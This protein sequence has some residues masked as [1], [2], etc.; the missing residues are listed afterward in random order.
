M[1]QPLPITLRLYRAA[2]MAFGPFAGVLLAHRQRRGKEDAARRP[3]RLGIAG[4]PRPQGRLCWLHGASVGES[5]TLL[6]V[7]ERL[8]A[9]GYRILLTTGTVTSAA[10]MAGRLPE[11]AIHQ[12]IPLDVP[13]FV[14][15]F[16]GHW[17]PDLAVFVESE[18]WPT[19]IS[20]VRAAGIPLA[21]VNGR[22]SPRSFARWQHVPRTIGAL[23]GC[24]DLIAAQSTADGDRFA[25][26][27]SHHVVPAGNLK[28]DAPPP[29]ADAAKLQAL[30]EA[31]G[32]RPLWVAAS[33][34]AGEEAV[35]GQ[36]HAGLKSRFPA[37]LTIIVPR[38][39]DRA[40][41]IRAELEAHKLV[42]AQRSQGRLPA[43]STD[44][45]LADTVGELGLFYRLARIVFVGKS[46]VGRGGQNPV[47]PAK[48]G[49][50]VLHGPFVHNFVEAFGAFD[51]MDGAITVGS[52]EEL[53]AAIVRLLADPTETG[54]IA[55]GGQEAV[56]SLT[57]ALDR[58]MEALGPLLAARAP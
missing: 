39:P 18:I 58:T 5:V 16:L 10:L 37:V 43:G 51:S 42:V 19:M 25:A 46:L 33:T 55:S 31:I 24:F 57:G 15:R 21:L 7:I 26:L 23:L 49:A 28:F 9:Q 1:S 3:E 35:A 8:A 50:A 44:I 22:M 53:T 56:A 4:K 38:H 13:A 2:T 52:S 17:R 34:H 27:G 45:Y 20:E 40:G 48:L 12:F 47:E 11:G 41:E 54:R 14:R 36:V 29:P 6:P 32:A 30:R